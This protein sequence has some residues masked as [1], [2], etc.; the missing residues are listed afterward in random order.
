MVRYIYNVP[1]SDVPVRGQLFGYVRTLCLQNLN[2]VAGDFIRVGFDT[3]EEYFVGPTN[4]LI[5]RA[6]DCSAESNSGKLSSAGITITGNGV[7]TVNILC[8]YTFYSATRATA[9]SIQVR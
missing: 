4:S 2:T 6:E 7:H 9:R 3:G 5:L 8:N 1:A